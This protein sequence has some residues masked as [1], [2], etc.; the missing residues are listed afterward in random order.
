[1]TKRTRSVD[2]VTPRY[3]S[4]VFDVD[5]TLTS[6]E[7]IDWLATLRG[8]R[9]AREIASLTDR[10]M[11]GE[12]T[13]ES[14]YAHRL[15][16]IKP[17]RAEIAALGQAYCDAV[18]R[19]A[20]GL[21]AV[22]AAAGTDVTIVSGGLRD[23]ILPLAAYLGVPAARVHA[24]FICFDSSDRY[25]SLDG[26]Q[27][28]A[29][30]RGKPALLH[31]LLLPRPCVMVGDGATDAAVRGVSDAFIAYTGV[32]RRAAVVAV[33]DAEAADFST[34]HALLFHPNS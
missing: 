28:L 33:A 32:T 19:G 4:V 31:A 16:L 27:L 14:V 22:L 30:Q 25:R 1:M 9:V 12:I 3:S 13:L 20:R 17:T 23:A 5:S 6:L 2:D 8:D 11:A 18:Q 24:V 29:T 10:A 7:G 15:E 34:L 21:C 26:A